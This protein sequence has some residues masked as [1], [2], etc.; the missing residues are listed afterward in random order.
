MTIVP[1]DSRIGPTPDEEQLRAGT[2]GLLGDLL[3]R[4]PDSPLLERLGNITAGETTDGLATAWLALGEAA[5]RTQ[6]ADLADEYQALFIGLGRGELIPYGSWYLTGFLMERPLAQLRRE[7][8]ELGFQR[9]EGVCEPEDHAAALCEIMALSIADGSM[10]LDR[11]RLFF[12]THLGS[13]MDR[14]FQ[15]MEQAAN[16]R[17]Y[18]SV[19]RLGQ[20]FIGLER[21]YLAFLA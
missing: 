6:P 10:D 17:F 1:A 13:W 12:E 4:P 7:L 3:R 21:R 2:Y 15:D 8:A 9:Q 16:A 14:F 18:R 11:Q 5:M 20:A 19:G